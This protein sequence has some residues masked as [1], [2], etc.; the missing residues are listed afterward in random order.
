[1]PLVVEV[2]EEQ[3]RDARTVGE[4]GDRLPVRRPLRVEV[5]A[6]LLRQHAHFVGLEVEHGDL[7]LAELERLE[8]RLRAALRREGDPAAVRRPRGLQVAVHVVRQLPQVAA[9]GV[10]HIQVGHPVREARE[11]DAPPV[12]RPGG[13]D[14]RDELRL[15]PP[16]RAVAPHVVDV[17]DVLAVALRREGEVA[18]VRRERALR[19]A[20][21]QLLVLGVER[22]L[23]EPRLAL[24]G[25]GVG[26][27]EVEEDLG[28]QQRAQRDEGDV[29]AVGR[30]R[31]GHVDVDEAA[32]AALREQRLRIAPRPLQL[33]DARQEGRLHVLLPFLAEVLEVGAGVA[34]EGAFDAQRDGGAHHLA[35]HLVAPA[36][37]D[38]GPEGFAEAVGEEQVRPLRHLLDAGD[39]AVERGVAHHGVG[40][41][42]AGAVRHVLGHPLHKP[43]RRLHAAEVLQARAGAAAGEDVELEDVHH[44][45][46]ERVLALPH[47]AGEEEHIALAQRVGD[48]ERAFARVADDVVLGELVARAPDDDRLALA[49]LVAEDAA[50]ALIGALGHLAGVARD[51]FQLR[52]V[53][54]VEVR[55]AEDLPAELAVL[56]LVLAEVRAHLRV[57]RRRGERGGGGEEGDSEQPT[58]HRDPQAVTATAGA[59]PQSRSSW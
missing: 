22:A 50:Q 47:I 28:A 27:V 17:E 11:H 18:A 56:D 57:E 12:G 4:E 29:A 14:H 38:V 39:V 54:H 46:R 48:A 55:R 31:G 52:V 6:R 33:G 3:L 36:A 26:E 32:R 42:V 43:Q 20:V 34:A 35:D 44:L 21:A 8:V 41:V 37:G 1:M 23:R 19:V 40:G 53:V 5:L 25:V 45:V 59:S 15:Q 2:E 7:P 16:V 9:V 10:D 58:A 13:A 24:A 30:E 49:E 51:F